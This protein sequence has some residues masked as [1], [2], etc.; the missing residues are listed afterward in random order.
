MGRRFEERRSWSNLPD[1]YLTAIGRVASEWAF[2][3]FE[4]NRHLITLHAHPL[5]AP[6]AGKP[7]RKDFRS[8]A[9]FWWQQVPAIYPRKKQ[10]E[11][12]YSLIRR[13][14]NARDNRDWVIHGRLFVPIPVEI[15]RQLGIARP[16]N[17]ATIELMTYG[18]ERRSWKTQTKFV[19][20]AWI[21]RL[22]NRIAVLHSDLIFFT[23]DELGPILRGLRKDSP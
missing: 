22:A 2:L 11:R 14:R 9:E 15:Q 18:E 13:A 20:A 4:I 1:A 10:Q 23:T 3:E 5:L 7:L 17:Q 19:N 21:E 12:A 8:R 16:T 6:E